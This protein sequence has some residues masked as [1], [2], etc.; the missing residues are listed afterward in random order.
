MAEL[1]GHRLRV[2][3]RPGCHLCEELVEALLPMARG[4]ID[5][6][7]VDVDMHPEWQAAYGTRIPVVELDGRLISEV[8]LD[9]AVVK[10]AIDAAGS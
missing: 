9:A 6:E 2:Y 3:S 1:P 10:R 5:V 8:T 4:R 7:V